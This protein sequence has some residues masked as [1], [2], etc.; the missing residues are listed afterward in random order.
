M[1]LA[2]KKADDARKLIAAG[3]D[4]SAARKADKAERGRQAEAQQ[5]ADA[6]LPG[7]GT[8]EATARD[9]LATVHGHKVRAGHA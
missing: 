9:W 5:L 4:P 3:T 2:R 7:P 1:A 8:F 6:G